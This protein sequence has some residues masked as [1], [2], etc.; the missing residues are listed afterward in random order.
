MWDI[1]GIILTVE[2][3][4][5]GEKPVYAYFVHNKPLS[6][7]SAL[8]TAMDTRC[9]THST[10]VWRLTSG[11]SLDIR[12]GVALLQG[13]Q[14]S[15][16]SPLEIAAKI[17]GHWLVHPKYSDTSLS[18]RQFF[19]HNQT[20]VG[21]VSNP[22]LRSQCSDI[23]AVAVA[24]PSEDEDSSECYLNIQFVLRSEQRR[25][26]WTACHVA[27]YRCLKAVCSETSRG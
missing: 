27:V 3:E 24:R 22:V 25:L 20:R 8:Q 26:D 4:I 23:S 2:A 7:L 5:H 21:S 9:L 18:Q 16:A 13:P 11:S 1:S 17:I 14:F 15:F 6:E 12:E 19:H 10:S